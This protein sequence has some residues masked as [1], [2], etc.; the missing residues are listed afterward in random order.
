MTFRTFDL[1]LLAAAFAGVFGVQ[2]LPGVLATLSSV[3]ICTV[4]SAFRAARSSESSPRVVAAFVAVASFWLMAVVRGVAYPLSFADGA[5]R[6][7]SATQFIDAPLV[8]LFVA[9]GTILSA[10]FGLLVGH[11]FAMWRD[12]GW[13]HIFDDP[14]G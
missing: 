13:R 11:Y 3:A 9:G 2:S 12:H 6:L 7:S 14:S 10:L 4:C 5:D 1:L 8:F